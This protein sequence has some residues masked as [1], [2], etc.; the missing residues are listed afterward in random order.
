MNPFHS[1]LAF[2]KAGSLNK[3]RNSYLLKSINF[4][5]MVFI[6]F[7]ILTVLGS[8]YF[9]HFTVDDN[10]LFLLFLSYLYLNLISILIQKAY[11]RFSALLIIILLLLI[12]S[13]ATLIFGVDFYL[14]DIMYPLIILI[15]AILIDVKFA[16]FVCLFI[17][18]IFFL[19]FFLQ[20]RAL[21]ISDVGWKTS[22]SIFPAALVV[23]ISYAT[24]LFLVY[25]S[26]KDAETKTKRLKKRQMEKLLDL[27]PLLNFGKLSKSLVCEIRNHL[28]IISIVLQNTKIDGNI[29]KDLDLATESVAQIDRLSNLVLYGFVNQLELE[30]FNLNLEIK[31]I[32]SLFKNKSRQRRIKII[33]EP[34]NNY[35]LHADRAKLN[36]VLVSLIFNAIESYEKVKNDDKHIFI[37]L[38][39]KP[40][41]LLIKVK[42][43]GMGIS[44]NELPL[45]FTPY[46]S[47][48]DR[49]K[50]LGLSLY[51]SQKVMIEV[52]ETKI[53]VESL[54]GTSSTF[55]LYIKN[56]FLLI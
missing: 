25:F 9:F 11:I 10:V 52:Y 12:L 41:S 55:T 56:K 53:K 48:K 36:R 15:S 50:S 18:S 5:L 42:D 26:F 34:N 3:K 21:M 28:S 6:L 27:A 39:K 38:V 13:K 40:R 4:T 44:K 24:V 31:N 16:V 8:G 51:V 7:V 54:L 33:F 43:Y 35:Q 46:F 23:L 20:S 2:E 22:L 17:F 49:R 1:L 32:V 37:K 19:C 30:V 47:S 14:V 29:I 45:I